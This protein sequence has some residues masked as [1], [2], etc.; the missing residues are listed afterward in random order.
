MRL[1]RR[2]PLVCF[3]YNPYQVGISGEVDPHAPELQGSIAFDYLFH[4]GQ[5][6]LDPK[7]S[8]YYTGSQY[9]ALFEIPFYELQARHIWNASLTY[10]VGTW[11][12]RLTSTISRTKPTSAASWAVRSSTVLPIST[13]CACEK[14]FEY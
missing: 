2:E 9:A 6:T 14:S 8:Y 1:S 7:I 10:D 4:V 11:V 5:G 3:N 12:W 13:G